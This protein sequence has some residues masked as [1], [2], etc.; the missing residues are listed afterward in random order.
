[1]LLNISQTGYSGEAD[2]FLVLYFVPVSAGTTEVAIAGSSADG[3]PVI[4]DTENN[5]I[6]AA[7]GSSTVIVTGTEPPPVVT[8]LRLHQNYPNPFNPETRIGFDIPR[9]STVNLKIFDVGG[10]HVR[11]LIRNVVYEVGTWETTWD[12]RSDAGTFVHSGIYFCVLEAACGTDSRKLV[13]LR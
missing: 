5:S 11:T 10:R 7:G 3:D 12:G 2:S 1:V 8:L 9:K 13:V 6:E 4:I